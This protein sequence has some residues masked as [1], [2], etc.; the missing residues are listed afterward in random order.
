MTSKFLAYLTIAVV[1]L[2]LSACKDTPSPKP[3]GYLRIDIPEHSY[4][5]LETKLPFSFEHATISQLKKVR[6][7]Q[8]TQENIEWYNIKYKAYNATIHL[9]YIPIV[10]NLDTLLEESHDFVF[11][12]TI[13]A[14]A[15][16]EILINKPEQKVYG[17]LYD[18]QGNTASNMEFYVSDS[19]QHF[20]R[21]ALYFETTPNIDSLAPVVNYIKQDIIHLINTFEWTCH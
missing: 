8:N 18:L 1:L 12:H 7:K 16:D 14:D 20:L 6:T 17:L 15:I 13:K 4:Q 21:G 3:H 11:E 9:S 5:T 2:G 19:S 10:N